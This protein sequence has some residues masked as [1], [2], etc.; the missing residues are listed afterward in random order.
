MKRLFLIISPY[1]IFCLLLS[2]PFILK[3]KK[4]INK[5]KEIENT[6]SKDSINNSIDTTQNEII[7]DVVPD[8]SPDDLPESYSIVVGS[9]KSIEKAE[10]LKSKLSQLNFECYQTQ[11]PSGLIRVTVGI[12]YSEIELKEE[13][14]SLQNL[15][16]EPWI[17]KLEKDEFASN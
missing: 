7:P 16:Y 2:I 3:P 6:I 15:G 9:F 14:D 5:E 13:F 11:L 17:T 12:G 4:Q 10:K 8:E 1:F